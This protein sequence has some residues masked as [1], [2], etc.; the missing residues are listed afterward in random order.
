MDTKGVI[1]N[2][3]YFSNINLL[4][5]HPYL[6]KRTW[7]F[8]FFS[9]FWSESHYYCINLCH[10]KY[11]LDILIDTNMFGSKP[12]SIPSYYTKRLYLHSSS[13]FSANDVVSSKMLV[14]RLIYLTNTKFDIIF[15]VQHLNQFVTPSTSVHQQVFK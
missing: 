5:S 4:P 13:H 12:I 15:L 6:F 14:V 7:W 3:I 2:I 8:K 11:A 10:H 9:G 1:L